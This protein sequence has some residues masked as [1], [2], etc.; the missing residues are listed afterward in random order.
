MLALS[1]SNPSERSPAR[2]PEGGGSEKP[3][4]CTAAKLRVRSEP[5]LT[6]GSPGQPAATA[7]LIFLLPHAPSAHLLLAHLAVE[8]LPL[9]PAQLLQELGVHVHLLKDLLQYRHLSS[10]AMG[11]DAFTPRV[12]F[13]LGYMLWRAYYKKGVVPTFGVY[14]T[15]H[16]FRDRYS[17][18]A[19]SR[20]MLPLFPP[21]PPRVRFAILHE[22]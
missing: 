16:Y 10:A 8:D 5:H 4:T 1:Q 21:P 20:D 15:S 18:L 3:C 13:Q 9:L 17:F 2:R 12:F 22:T 14:V 6:R 7:S 11:T 19:R